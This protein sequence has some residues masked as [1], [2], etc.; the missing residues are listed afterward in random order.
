MVPT[1]FWN[2]FK[3]YRWVGGQPTYCI[4][5]T[6]TEWSRRHSGMGSRTIDGSRYLECNMTTQRFHDEISCYSKTVQNWRLVFFRV[7]FGVILETVTS[8][9]VGSRGAACCGGMDDGADGAG[10]TVG[11]E[12]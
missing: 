2:G 5:K 4:I 8:A 6:M 10:S 1:P 12:M 7:V 9:E 11:P 3:D